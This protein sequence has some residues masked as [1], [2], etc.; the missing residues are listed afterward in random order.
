MYSFNR[1]QIHVDRYV[2]KIINYNNGSKKWDRK[3]CHP[4]FFN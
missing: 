3:E 1:T 2:K 4:T